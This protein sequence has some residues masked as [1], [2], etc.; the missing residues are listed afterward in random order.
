MAKI[1]PASRKTS[2]KRSIL[3]KA[4]ASNNYTCGYCGKD[5]CCCHSKGIG[6]TLLILGVIFLI[7]DLGGFQWWTVNWW[8]VILII[9]G[10]WMIRK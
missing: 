10:L 2:T 4:T 6:W 5:S 3:P 9:S 1:K 7:K 8:T